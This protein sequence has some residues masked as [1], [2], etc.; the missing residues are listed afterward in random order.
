MFEG[1][2]LAVEKFSRQRVGAL[3]MKMG[4]GKTKTAL[5]L[6]KLHVDRYDVLV[7]LT[8]TSTVNNLLT[9]I[10]KQGG[11]D[12]PLI[13]KGYETIASS[14][15]EWLEL[16]AELNGKRIFLVCDESLFLKNG[17][18]KRWR[19]A[20]QLREQF[21]DF[22]LCLN[23][24]PLSRDEMDIYWQMRLL[25]PLILGVSENQFRNIM[26]TKFID[27][28]EHRVWWK[29]C[30]KNVGWLKARIEPYVYECDLNLNVAVEY[31]DDECRLTDDCRAEYQRVKKELLNA[32]ADYEENIIMRTMG[33]LKM[34][35]ACDEL[36]NKLIARQIS[37][38]N[39][40]SLVFCCYRDEQE[41][42]AKHIK[43]GYFMINGDT[44]QVERKSIIKVGE[45]TDNPLLLTLGT[46]SVGL[47]LQH[48]SMGVMASLPGDYA[49]YDQAIHRIIRNGQ[50]ADRVRVV[51]WRQRIGICRM[52][53]ECL[54]RKTTLAQLIKETDWRGSL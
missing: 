30:S 15:R 19:R 44:S 1:Q 37:E 20:N 23:G 31:Q 22:A 38:M 50:Q 39:N 2:R 33:E 45:Q 12:K 41:Q 25:S 51:K 18:T 8:P 26:F 49:T 34:M 36:K 10:K 5:E 53:D 16:L 6:A 35:V 14:D 48:A 52:V 40:P 32:I 47:N 42:I 28:Q 24:T 11:I 29:S 4:T 9:E 27:R 7:W 54:W 3:F 21:A 17:K 43:N 46:G 13:A